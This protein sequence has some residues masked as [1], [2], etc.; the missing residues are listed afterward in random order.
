M[1]FH[2]VKHM[3]VGYAIGRR[4]TTEVGAE[5]DERQA[6]AQVLT[7]RKVEPKQAVMWMQMQWD[8][9]V[10]ACVDSTSRTVEVWWP[11]RQVL[12]LAL[13]V[14]ETVRRSRGTESGRLWPLWTK[15]V[16]RGGP[17][18]TLYKWC[19]RKRVPQ[20]LQTRGST[21]WYRMGSHGGLWNPGGE[22][23]GGCVYFGPAEKG[24]TPAHAVGRGGG[25]GTGWKS[26]PNT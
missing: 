20:G 24:E 5:A 14:G 17:R 19:P 12:A 9:Q 1:Y 4:G 2:Q 18:D 16:Q 10:A 26:G 13:Y 7:A 22:T 6:K 25:G 8:A 15:A 3:W 11:T 23:H 21:I